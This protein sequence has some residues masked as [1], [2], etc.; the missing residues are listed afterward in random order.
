MKQRLLFIEIKTMKY[1]NEKCQ[2]V[3]PPWQPIPNLQGMPPWLMEYAPATIS[4]NKE[5]KELEG[6]SRACQKI[7]L[8]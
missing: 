5:D 2:W 6:E 4:K 3:I 8:I 7:G 1:T